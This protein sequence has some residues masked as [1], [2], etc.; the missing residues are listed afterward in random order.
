MNCFWEASKKEPN[1][2]NRDL[3]EVNYYIIDDYRETKE[4]DRFKGNDIYLKAK[5]IILDLFIT[6]QNWNRVL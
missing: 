5:I 6:K 2:I 3:I 1:L 4:S